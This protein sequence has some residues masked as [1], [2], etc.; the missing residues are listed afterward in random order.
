MPATRPTP[1]PGNNE[2]KS[3]NLKNLV[4]SQCPAR[5]QKP[6]KG[7]RKRIEVHSGLFGMFFSVGTIGGKL[8]NN[9]KGFICLQSLAGVTGVNLAEVDKEERK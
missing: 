9:M 6:S 4:C 5:Q 8:A 7:K 3:E 2:A 1:G